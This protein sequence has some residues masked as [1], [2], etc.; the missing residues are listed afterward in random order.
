M[1][2]LLLATLI[3]SPVAHAQLAQDTVTNPAPGVVVA[4]NYV[5]ASNPAGG[6]P[7]LYTNG[8]FISQPTGGGPSGTDPVSILQSPD[9]AFGSGCAN[10]PFR[11][12]DDFT[13]PAGGWT[14]QRVDVFGYQTQT[15][16]GGSTVSP[17]TT[18]T[19]RIWNGPPNAGGTIVFGDTTT[20][21]QTTT[22]WS[23][24]WRV[25]STALTNQQRPIMRVSMDN[26]NITLPAGTYWVDFGIAPASGGAFCPPNTSTSATNNALQ[27][28]TA[29]DT[30]QA[31][32]DGGS[33]RPL[34]FPFQLFGTPAAQPPVFGYTPAPGSTVTA[35]GGTGLVGSTSNL[36]ITPSIATPGTGT[37]AAATTTLT[38]TAPSAPFAG[39]GQTVTAIGSGAISGGPLA[40]TCTRGTA[41][42][43]QTLTCSENQGGTAVSRTWT[44]SCPA[45]TIPSVPVNATSAW[46]LIALMLA[47]FGFAAV[48][49]RRQG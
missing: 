48:M 14:I 23:G 13:V 24:V 25:L 37:G 49:V 46:S 8:S 4:P 32:V 12:A 19:L 39:F 20:N 38:C 40:G 35:T 33:G 45:G 42:V 27:L 15:A 2:R 31:V 47:M 10:N 44:L 5:P 28:A 43:T 34:D 36:T 1:R 16:P 9:T 21:R 22:G 7:S 29:P 26:L 41:A 6:P 11:L 17:F 3:A 18:G 30:W